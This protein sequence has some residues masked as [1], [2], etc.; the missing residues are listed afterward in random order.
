VF[1]DLFYFLPDITENA[2]KPLKNDI[3]QMTR[4]EIHPEGLRKSSFFAIFPAVEKASP[5]LTAAP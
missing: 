1:S 4:K 2:Y 5:F 3:E